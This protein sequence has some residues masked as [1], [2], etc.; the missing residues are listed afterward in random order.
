MT[1]ELEGVIKYEE[2]VQTGVYLLYKG[3]DIVY[4]G[5][6]KNVRQRVKQHMSNDRLDFD[7]FL[8]IPCPK[9]IA[10][11]LEHACISA[12]RPMYNSFSGGAFW[13][14]DLEVN[15]EWR[16]V[17]IV[18]ENTKIGQI[19]G[20]VTVYVDQVIGTKKSVQKVFLMR[21]TIEFRICKFC[22]WKLNDEN[23]DIY[24]ND[25]CRAKDTE[26]IWKMKLKMK[27]YG[28]Q[29]M[30]AKWWQNLQSLRGQHSENKTKG[31]TDTT[32]PFSYIN[33]P[34]SKDYTIK[35]EEL[36]WKTW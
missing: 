16:F 23:N 32:P 30:K 6:S 22:E 2:S 11:Y 12:I 7:K 19:N 3:E 29:N 28:N 31:V 36:Q 8:F 20:F 26:V 17:L 5:I 21:D 9:E 15:E 18:P 35:I 27:Y 4:V 13:K 14:N 24:C 1:I 34:T 25:S 10:P 33:T